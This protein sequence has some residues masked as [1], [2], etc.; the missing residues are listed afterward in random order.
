[1]NWKELNSGINRVMQNYCGDPKTEN[2]M[3]IGLIALKELEQNDA[4]EIYAGDPHKLGRTLDVLDLI[5]CSQIIIHACMARK[6]S[7]QTLDFNR[8]DYPDMDPP[9]WHKWITVKQEDGEVKTGSLPI[10]FW[11][12]LKEGYEEHNKDY[13]GWYKP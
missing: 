2:L 3:Q 6:A 8:L 9:E 10:D 4:A 1:L 11:G 13:E 12:P 5:T 7:S